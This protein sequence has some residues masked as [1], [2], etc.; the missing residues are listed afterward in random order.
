MIEVENVSFRYGSIHA[1]Q[2]VTQRFSAGEF[3]SIIGRN[4]SGKTTLARCMAGF[5][6]PESG[7]IHVDGQR[8]ATE[9]R[10]KQLCENAVCSIAR[11]AGPVVYDGDARALQ[12]GRVS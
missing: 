9:R 3:A 11:G 6:R 1:L 4:G 2:E 8:M 5:L 10:S 7:S 12:A